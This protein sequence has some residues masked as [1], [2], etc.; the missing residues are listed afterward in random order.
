MPP[1]KIYIMD[2]LNALQSHCSER[3]KREKLS[4]VQPTSFEYSSIIAQKTAP[5]YIQRVMSSINFDSLIEKDISSKS[6][7][8]EKSLVTCDDET[9]PDQVTVTPVP[10]SVSR[11]VEE[12]AKNVVDNVQ[13]EDQIE[14]V[15]D[16]LTCKK[17]DFESLIRDKD[18][19]KVT[20]DKKFTVYEHIK[21]KNESGA[22]KHLSHFFGSGS[23][24]RVS[25]G[26]EFGHTLKIADGRKE[27]KRRNKR[28]ADTQPDGG[29]LLFINPDFACEHPCTLAVTGTLSRAD[30]SFSSTGNRDNVS[31]TYKTTFWSNGDT[32]GLE[33][34]N[35]SNVTGPLSTFGGIV[36]SKEGCNDRKSMPGWNGRAPMWVPFRECECVITRC[37]DFNSVTP[38]NNQEE[39]ERESDAH[40]AYPRLGT[41]KTFNSTYNFQ[42]TFSTRYDSTSPDLALSCAEASP[43]DHKIISPTFG[44]SSPARLRLDGN[45]AY[46]T[47][48][49]CK[50][51]ELAVEKLSTL[52]HK[53]HLRDTGG[54]TFH[55]N[56]PAL[57][58]ACL[59]GNIV[60]ARKLLKAGANPNRVALST[61]TT[62]LHDAVAGGHH[63]VLKLLLQ[64]NA[65]QTVRDEAGKT[66]LHVCCVN[67]DVAGARQLLLHKK[68]K[69][70]LGIV[71][72]KGRSPRMSCTK[73]YLRDVIE[74][75]CKKHGVKEK[76]KTQWW[77]TLT[78]GDGPAPSELQK[79]T[80]KDFM[81]MAVL[82][83]NPNRM[84]K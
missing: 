82:V 70:A 10:A 58:L 31:V 43:Y 7:Q 78:G 41:S 24:V 14:L 71:D 56:M 40:G 3:K 26:N 53:F 29:M 38:N 59:H 64:F 34:T 60:A 30:A 23:S 44:S 5:K 48:Y 80:A 67:N 15:A 27:T 69:M 81:K 12:K 73:K 52:S 42:N 18:M 9:S 11:V 25:I 21:L 66:P 77:A 19:D 6:G 55:G 33:I 22:F 79:S 50:S 61:G 63:D 20:L 83:A 54:T 16:L 8:D 65:D 1:P 76:K 37:P 17:V 75:E 57:S 47:V 2:E 4:S 35:S 45:V 68:A 39:S 62:P 13:S 74:G 32:N 49:K 84:K 46:V 28:V 36:P 72:R 51:I